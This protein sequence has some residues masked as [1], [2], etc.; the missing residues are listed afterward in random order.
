MRGAARVAFHRYD[1]FGDKTTGA[2]LQLGMRGRDGEVHA[3]Y[4]PEFFLF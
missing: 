4:L 3:V 1:V 2:L